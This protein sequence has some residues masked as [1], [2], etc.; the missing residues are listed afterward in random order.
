MLLEQVAR[1]LLLHNLSGRH[2][3]PVD[4]LRKVLGSDVEIAEEGFE[5]DSNVA[6]GAIPPLG[7][8]AH[9]SGSGEPP[10]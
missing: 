2:D 10:V 8:Q 4:G 6:I 9:A 1:L 3:L 5:V 7:F